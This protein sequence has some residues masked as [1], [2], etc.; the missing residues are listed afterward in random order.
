M[1]VRALND[2]SVIISSSIIIMSS[3]SMISCI[4]SRLPITITTSIIISM[5]IVL[6]IIG[7]TSIQQY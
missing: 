6:T 4:R 1:A 3:S 2:I 5:S 7:I